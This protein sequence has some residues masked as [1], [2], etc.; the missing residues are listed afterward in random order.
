MGA[1][2]ADPLLPRAAISHREHEG[3][4]MSHRFAGAFL[5][6]AS[7]G[8]VCGLAA[9]G[10]TPCVDL[11]ALTIPSVEITSAA[12]LPAGPF[13]APGSRSAAMLPAFCRVEGIARP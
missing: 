10:G 8:G 12:L 4:V 5:L 7:L 9:A 11:K 13:T 6:I 2:G 1:T 3:P